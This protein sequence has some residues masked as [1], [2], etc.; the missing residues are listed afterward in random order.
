MKTAVDHHRILFDLGSPCDVLSAWPAEAPVAL[1]RMGDDDG[2]AT[3]TTL[4][5]RPMGWFIH[6]GCSR[7]VGS[8]PITV[9]KQGFSN[10]P[11]AD[12]ECVLNAGSLNPPCFNACPAPFHGGWIGSLSYD[13]GAK[14]EPTGV[15]PPRRAVDDR[16]WPLITLGWC[17]AALIY[18]HAAQRWSIAGDAAEAADLLRA[19]RPDAG[20]PPAPPRLGDVQSSFDPDGYVHAVSEALRYIAAGDIFQVNITQRLSAAISGSSRRLALRALAGPEAVFGAYLE[21]PQGRTLLSMSPEL[22]VRLDGATRRLVTWPIKGTLRSGESID[23][24]ARSEKDR[25]ELHMIVDLMRNDLGR[26]CD[27]GSV[28]TPRPRRLA[29]FGTV[30]HGIGEV[31]G[32]LRDGA[33]TADLIRAV[34]P[35]GSITGAPKIR[36]MG[37]IDELE[38]VRRGAYCGSIG[39]FSSC[40]NACLNVAIRTMTLTGARRP[41]RWDV[42]DDG[43]LDYGAGGGVVAD[44]DPLAEYRESLDK[45]AVL[46]AALRL[47]AD[48]PHDLSIR[49]VS[50]G[51]ALRRSS[52]ICW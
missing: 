11:L 43:M 46:R 29:T 33:T 12:L 15:H 6:D 7:I 20:P 4:F 51:H 1:L 32:R 31:V 10:D 13:L 27:F 30:H 37:I 44:S 35:A 25:A 19:L 26:V 38:P 22:L 50:R 5:A 14:V 2:L 41:R 21:L 23:S 28:R 34:F 16:A 49:S 36:A 47:R 40:G 8:T 52:S 48:A 42:L 17:P 18:D 3:R 39:C 45:T 24:L 9:N